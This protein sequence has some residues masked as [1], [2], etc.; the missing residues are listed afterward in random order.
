YQSLYNVGSPESQFVEDGS[1]IRLKDLSISYDLKKLVKVN[2]ISHL[3]VTLSGRNLLTFTKYSGLDPENTGAFDTQ[4]NN[5]AN[6]R[7]GA[8]SG[9]DYFGVPNL[10]SYQFS[11]NVGF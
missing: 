3:S 4:G 1:Y 6:T 11:L 10:R 2:S 8:F 9:V 5:L 7:S